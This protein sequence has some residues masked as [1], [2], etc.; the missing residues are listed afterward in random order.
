M[1][2]ERITDEEAEEYGADTYL[3]SA[4]LAIFL[5][6]SNVTEDPEVQSRLPRTVEVLERLNEALGEVMDGI[7]WAMDPEN[8]GAG[9]EEEKTDRKMFAI[10]RAAFG[11]RGEGETGEEDSLS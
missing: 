6:L 2:R 10:L 9:E 11:V 4:P 8:P 3:G 1:V 7:N 5:N